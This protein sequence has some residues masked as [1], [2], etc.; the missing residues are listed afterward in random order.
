MF[1]LRYAQDGLSARSRFMQ[2][3]GKLQGRK[4]AI[5]N[6]NPEACARV[7][8]SSNNKGQGIEM[9]LAC[10]AWDPVYS[11]ESVD[12]ER[13]EWLSKEFVKLYAR[14]DWQNKIAHLTKKHVANFAKRCDE[15]REFVLDAE[16]ISRLTAHI[17]F[18]LA[19]SRSMTDIENDV[20]YTASL[21][22]RKEIAVKGKASP[23]AKADFWEMLGSLIENSEFANDLKANAHQRNMYLSLFAQ[24]LII[25]P[26]INF[27]DIMSAVFKHLDSDNIVREKAVHAAKAGDVEH[28]QNICMESIRLNH[29]FPV[30]ERELTRK[31]KVVDEEF[32][33]GTQIY[34]MLDEFKQEQDFNP[35]RWI[36]GA[37]NPYRSMPF[38]TGQRM[39]LGKQ[40]ATDMM[41]E[42]L[43]GIL[44]SF[45]SD[46]IRPSDNHLYSG[47]DNDGK[48]SISTILYQLKIF[49]NALK[50][51]FMIG[52]S[53]KVVAKA[54]A[55]TGKCPFT[56]RSGNS[57]P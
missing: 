22:W 55:K 10:P 37:K 38:G 12:G 18:D 25:S 11:I 7:L 39:C 21:E 46:R 19:F 49:S 53:N 54:A 52:Q 31:L 29:P 50:Q 16:Q 42:M 30:L 45:P 20:F 28:M 56:G 41:G 17:L 40:L 5:L 8:A 33:A 51:S 43:M 48:D 23:K 34:I 32:E 3:C 36:K 57:A 4:V 15:D 27:S 14:L 6:S 24:P 26:Q 1:S 44:R 35:D 9:M 13:W 2:L 47:R